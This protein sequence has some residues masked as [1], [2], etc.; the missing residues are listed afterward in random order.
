MG[1]NQTPQNWSK[2]SIDSGIC[3]SHQIETHPILPGIPFEGFDRESP[4][5]SPRYF[6]AELG[7]E[8]EAHQFR[9]F[10]YCTVHPPIRENS[11]HFWDF[12]FHMSYRW[13]CIHKLIA[14]SRSPMFP[15]NV[16]SPTLLRKRSWA[17]SSHHFVYILLQT[18]LEN[19]PWH[20]TTYHNIPQHTNEH[21][22][23]QAYKQNSPRLSPTSKHVVPG[24]SVSTQKEAP[25]VTPEAVCLDGRVF[26]GVKKLGKAGEHYL[27]SN[28]KWI[29]HLYLV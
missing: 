26:E 22:S 7:F 3:D 10:Q 5:P 18:I 14:W 12:H 1:F 9:L 17:L 28:S 19:Q 27:Y 15:S 2:L 6:Q 21:I 24:T 8:F 11:V 20:T 29:S 16:V 4:L 25:E 23:K 13:C